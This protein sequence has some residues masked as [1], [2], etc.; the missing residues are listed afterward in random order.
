[1]TKDDFRKEL[2]K[3][4]IGRT[5]YRILGYFLYPF[6]QRTKV[7]E[8]MYSGRGS[9]W[10]KTLWYI[11][12]DDELG[13]PENKGYDF[14]LPMAKEKGIPLWF[15]S[16]WFNAIRN[17]AYN[18]VLAHAPKVDAKGDYRIV[19]KTIDKIYQYGKKIAPQLW[20]GWSLQDGKVVE[21][22]SKTG[23]GEVWYNP[24]GNKDFLYMR[25]SYTR[26]RR[27]LFWNFYITHKEGDFG[28]KF[29]IEHKIY[30]KFVDFKFWKGLTPWKLL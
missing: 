3:A 21:K 30:G 26:K 20:A 27:F 28:E 19:E 2:R 18:Y 17:S 29:D 10:T 8:K 23:I 4:V 24:Q 11:L 13:K 1:M 22:D 9:K 5:K 25:Y 15:A 16:Y 12:N 14:N 6:I 7:R